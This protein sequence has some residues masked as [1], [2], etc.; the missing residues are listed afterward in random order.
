MRVRANLTLKKAV[1]N[2]VYTGKTHCAVLLCETLL[3]ERLVYDTLRERQRAPR[4]LQKL[5]FLSAYGG[6]APVCVAA[7]SMRLLANSKEDETKHLRGC[8]KSG[9]L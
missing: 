3:Y 4:G 7:N 2:R 8:L 5:Y 6:V 9:W 1:R